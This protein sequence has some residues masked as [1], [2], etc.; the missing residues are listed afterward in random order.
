MP[1][2]ISKC[3]C[4]EI[5]TLATLELVMCSKRSVL[6]RSM[7]EMAADNRSMGDVATHLVPPSQRGPHRNER[8]HQR[9][10]VVVFC[11]MNAILKTVHGRDE[12][13]LSLFR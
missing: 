13:P 10:D 6:M 5:E 12:P 9:A 3:V 11:I 1:G 8:V 4:D 2:P 7:T